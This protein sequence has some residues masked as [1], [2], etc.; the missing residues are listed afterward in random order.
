MHILLEKAILTRK[1]TSPSSDSEAISGGYFLK[2]SAGKTIQLN[3]EH[4]YVRAQSCI[5][6]DGSHNGRLAF[7]KTSLLYASPAAVGR[8]GQTNYKGLIWAALQAK[9]SLR[10][11]CILIAQIKA[12]SMLRCCDK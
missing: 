2:A 3:G 12:F 4:E 8:K 1:Q 9:K 7:Q 6:L 5:F 10:Y 11:I